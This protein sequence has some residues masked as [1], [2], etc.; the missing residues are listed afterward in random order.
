M[1]PHIPAIIEAATGSAPAGFAALHGGC[2]SDVMRVDLANGE[3]VVIKLGDETTGLEQEAMRLRYLAERS[4]LPVPA[5]IHAEARVLVMTWIETRGGLTDAAQEHAAELLADLHGITAEACGF[6]EG[7][8]SGGLLKPAP[9]TAS[10]I[11]FFREHRLLYT[12]RAALESGRL[13]GELMP[14]LERLAQ[15]VER[16]LVE[17]ERPALIHGDMW[18]GNVLCRDGRIAA[19]VDPS[20]YYAH[21]EQELAY[22][23]LFG[24]FG[25]PFFRRYHAIRPIQPGFFEERL[26]MYNLYHLLIHVR[27][28]GGSYVQ[29]TADTLDFY[30]C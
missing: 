1:D 9:W 16:R 21:P 11:A 17:P 18:T 20:C 24:T 14:R 12:A 4:R 8:M 25:R 29:A 22:S 19:F 6:D 27:L 2:V 3:R 28:F 23:T 7:S 15:Q 10:W 26:P 30:G 13:P 5:V